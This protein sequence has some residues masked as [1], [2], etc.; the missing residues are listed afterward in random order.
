MG[1]GQ[2]KLM[3]RGTFSGEI[4]V[5][6]GFGQGEDGEVFFWGQGAV[7]GAVG[8]N[9]ISIIIP[10]HRVVGAAGSLTGYAGG[11]EKKVR[12]LQ[13]FGYTPPGTVPC[14]VRYW[15]RHPPGP[16]GQVFPAGSF[17][18]ILAADLWKQIITGFFP[19]PV[20]NGKEG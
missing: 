3:G 7:G 18:G 10:C 15:P 6:P 1:G 12:L 8:H 4:A 13:P 2:G 20:C 11:L 19:S 16:P 17:P 9:P 14:P 5:Q